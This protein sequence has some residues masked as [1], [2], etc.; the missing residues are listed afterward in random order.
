MPKFWLTVTEYDLKLLKCL[1]GVVQEH[2]HLYVNLI[3]CQFWPMQVQ[4][5]CTF[6]CFIFKTPKRLDLPLPLIGIYIIMLLVFIY[7]KLTFSCFELMKEAS[8]VFKRSL[9]QNTIVVTLHCMRWFLGD[10]LKLK[11]QTALDKHLTL[12]Y[13]LYHIY[14]LTP[15]KKSKAEE[16]FTL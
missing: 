15:L 9:P 8:S 3:W 12:F 13:L 5:R 11:A 14:I 2:F 10:Q 6:K 4:C 16:I 1:K 7:W